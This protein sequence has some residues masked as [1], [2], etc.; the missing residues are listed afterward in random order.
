MRLTRRMA[1]V[2]RVGLMTPIA[3]VVLRNE[4]RNVQ[5]LGVGSVSMP[6]PVERRGCRDEPPSGVLGNLF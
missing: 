6:R 4:K 2:E 1:A 5:Q 3:P